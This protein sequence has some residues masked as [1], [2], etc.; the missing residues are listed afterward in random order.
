MA[1]INISNKEQFG[2]NQYLTKYGSQL[3]DLMRPVA[4]QA[5]K[6]LYGDVYQSIAAQAQAMINSG[7]LDASEASSYV[8][9][10]FDLYMNPTA[11]M[12]SGS[13]ADKLTTIYAMQNGGLDNPAS[14]LQGYTNANRFGY[15]MAGNNTWAKGAI[16][17]AWGLGSFRLRNE[18][19]VGQSEKELK[20]YQNKTTDEL[21][22]I[23][24]KQVSMADDFNTITDQTE[25][26][27]TNWTHDIADIKTAVGK[28][29]YDTGKKVIDYLWTLIAGSAMLSLANNL[30]GN[31]GQRWFNE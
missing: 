1:S 3:I 5:N 19:A 31:G 20:N 9:R 6:E 15:S 13:V 22:D 17:G 24:N 8:N 4:L 12:Q 16:Q 7:E 27:Y 21:E 10:A 11:N 25:K 14:F 28:D 18:N 29:I 30:L 2:Q 23:Y 26:W